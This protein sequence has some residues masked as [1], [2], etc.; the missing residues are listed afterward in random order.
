MKLL[1]WLGITC[2]LLII[3]YFLGPRPAT[4]KYG[5]ELPNI[6]V[7]VDQLDEYISNK[8]AKFKVKPDNQARIIWAN[9]SLK[10]QTE[11]AVVYIHG[12]SASQEEGD[13]VHYSFAHK[14]GCNLYLSRLNAHG[15][16]TDEPL[17]DMTAA[18]L[19]ESAKEAYAI[20]KKLGKKV[21][22]MATSTGGTLAIKLASEYP[23]IAGL[24]LMSPNIE[25][26][27]SKAWM[28][29]NHWGLQIARLF[30]G[31]YNVVA[32]TTAIY[33]QYW[34]NRYRMEATVQLEELLETTMKESVFKKVTQ[35]LLLLY[36][37]MDE[38]HQDSVV[39]VSAMKRMFDQISTPAA[40]KREEAIPFAGNHVM[41]SYIKSK[42]LFSVQEACDKFA[43]DI[44][45]LQ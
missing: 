32:D 18:G 23:E 5:P 41:G 9:D 16:I 26:N 2:F 28:L 19:Y 34:N 12:F 27:D 43:R 42:D 37:Y 1:K 22:L 11:Y 35:P 30:K 7:S 25:I 40:L 31:K 29:N 38:I 15:L 17:L 21:I 24:I 14:F 36:Y 3:V 10:Q 45:H 20:G 13:P 39:R 4:P 6:A 33:A 8:E 44:L